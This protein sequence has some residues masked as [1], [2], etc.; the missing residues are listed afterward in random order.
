MINNVTYNETVPPPLLTLPQLSEQKFYWY[1]SPRK[2]KIYEFNTTPNGCQRVFTD[3]DA[4]KQYGK[5]SILASH[6]VSY[7]NLFVNAVLQPKENYKVEE[8]KITLLTDEM[9]RSGTPINLQMIKI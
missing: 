6:K 9:P 7:M 1:A 4:L 8:G 2:V 3:Q 5:Q